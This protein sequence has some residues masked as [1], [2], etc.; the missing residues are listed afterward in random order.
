MAERKGFEP[1]MR[2]PPYSLSRGAPSATRPPL[3]QDLTP[4]P[5]PAGVQEDNFSILPRSAHGGVAPFERRGTGGLPKTAIGRSLHG[6][7]ITISKAKPGV[8]TCKN[9]WLHGMFNAVTLSNTFRFRPATFFPLNRSYASV[10]GTIGRARNIGTT[11]TALALVLKCPG[12]A[13]M[14][15]QLSCCGDS[16]SLRR[17]RLK[18][19]SGADGRGC[20]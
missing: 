16:A 20:L 1:S 18:C 15:G 2:F 19:R 17:I 11:N 5:S 12:V 3:R 7:S 13:A 10:F 4:R 6:P 8:S 14:V 9:A